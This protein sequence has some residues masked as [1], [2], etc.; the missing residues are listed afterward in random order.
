[1]VLCPLDVFGNSVVG[2]P[3]HL[4]DECPNRYDNLFST[5]RRRRS[6]AKN[7]NVL[8]KTIRQEGAFFVRGNEAGDGANSGAK[9]GNNAFS[10]G[11]AIAS[12]LFF[13]L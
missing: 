1:M 9:S 5:G 11:L 8:I 10:F 12:L 6:F 7:S 13:A 3:C 4:S 2:S